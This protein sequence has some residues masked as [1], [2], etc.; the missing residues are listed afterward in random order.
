M[1][2]HYKLQFLC[3][4]F[5]RLF[6]HDSESVECA[7]LKLICVTGCWHGDNNNKNT[8][9]ATTWCKQPAT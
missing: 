7:Q 2:S 3:A 8:A 6:V 5:E 9:S 4:F 1:D